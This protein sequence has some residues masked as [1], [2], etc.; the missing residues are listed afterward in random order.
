MFGIRGLESQEEIITENVTSSV[1]LLSEI[2][3]ALERFQIF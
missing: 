3:T 1:Y 2:P